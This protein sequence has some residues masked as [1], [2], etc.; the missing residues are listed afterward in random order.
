[1]VGIKGG[2][3]MEACSLPVEPRDRFIDGRAYDDSR[4]NGVEAESCRSRR[5]EATGVKTG[6]TSEPVDIAAI[7]EKQARP[8]TDLGAPGIL[9][10]R[11]LRTVLQ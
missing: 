1:V 9:D 6:F 4:V 5:F 8:N 3:P 2:T 7:R 10:L 11:R